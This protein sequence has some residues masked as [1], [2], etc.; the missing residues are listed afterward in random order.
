MGWL[1]E[2]RDVFVLPSVYCSVLHRIGR[3]ML[4]CLIQISHVVSRDSNLEGCK[5]CSFGCIVVVF[6]CCS[7][8]SSVLCMHADD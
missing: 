5:F 7:N 1:V 3:R 6:A 2:S 4:C 8:R